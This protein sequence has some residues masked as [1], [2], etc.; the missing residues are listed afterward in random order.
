MWDAAATAPFVMLEP[1]RAPGQSHAAS[2]GAFRKA[3]GSRSTPTALASS[4]LGTLAT[5]SNEFGLISERDA[6]KAS[7]TMVLG[8]SASVTAPRLVATVNAVA[9]TCEIVPRTCTGGSGA[10][11]WAGTSAAM[12]NE[13]TA[14]TVVAALSR[15]CFGTIYSP[16]GRDLPSLARPAAGVWPLIV[17]KREPTMSLSLMP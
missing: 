10:A 17:C 16:F 7:T 5:P 13:R 1:P 12:R 2:A 6:G 8:P 11:A 9:V 4:A 14:A 3:L 15:L